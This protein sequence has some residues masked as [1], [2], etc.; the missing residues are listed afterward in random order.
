MRQTNFL[1]T[2][3]IPKQY[4]HSLPFLVTKHRKSEDSIHVPPHHIVS[5]ICTDGLNNSLP[6]PMTHKLD[7]PVI[8]AT[9][10][11]TTV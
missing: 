3:F 8:T 7:M 5:N 2:F 10:P 9:E 1:Y 11:I 6:L 4:K